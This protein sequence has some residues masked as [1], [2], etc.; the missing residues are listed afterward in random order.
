MGLWEGQV[1]HID[2]C[3]GKD[4]NY[5]LGFAVDLLQKYKAGFIIYS[6]NEIH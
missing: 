2:F 3:V 4:L 6:E 5:S 1:K